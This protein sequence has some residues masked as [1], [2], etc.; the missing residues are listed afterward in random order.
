MF[1]EKAAG[2]TAEANQEHVSNRFELRHNRCPIGL[3]ARF[4][5]ILERRPKLA[6]P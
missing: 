5:F 1:D 4:P 6:S 3:P 2:K